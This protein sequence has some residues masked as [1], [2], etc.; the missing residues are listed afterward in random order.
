MTRFLSQ[1]FRRVALVLGVVFGLI[2][3]AAVP[4]AAAPA[5]PATK[6]KLTAD[7]RVLGCNP[8]GGGNVDTVLRN[9][10]QAERPFVISVYRAGDGLVFEG[11]EAAVPGRSVLEYR[12]LA[13]AKYRIVVSAG[14]RVLDAER[15][16]FR[17]CPA[18]PDVPPPP[19]GQP[20]VRRLVQS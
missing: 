12:G 16:D 17:V 19:P 20:L 4:A 9:S 10:T 5:F 7:V 11:D 3:G 2:A 18:L 1:P 13:P 14:G 15:A 8:E 6:P